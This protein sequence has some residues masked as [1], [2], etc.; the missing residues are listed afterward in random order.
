MACEG[1]ERDGRKGEWQGGKGKVVKVDVFNHHG[2]KMMIPALRAPA[3]FFQ[4]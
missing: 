4:S 2:I 3:V 1:W